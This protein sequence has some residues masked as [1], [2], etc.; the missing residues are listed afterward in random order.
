MKAPPGVDVA[1]LQA[2]LNELGF[3]PVKLR[4]LAESFWSR[5]FAFESDDEPMVARVGRRVDFYNKDRIAA[6]WA[7]AALPVP[8]INAIEPF[9]DAWVAV[10][11]R[12]D[13]EPLESL[14]RGEFD[15]I[16]DQL[17]AAIQAIG[18][19]EPVGKG[20]GEFDLRG[21][22]AYP[23]WRS[24]L[25]S[26]FTDG[27]KGE[28]P[29]RWLDHVSKELGETVAAAESRLAELDLA[30]AARSPVHADLQHGNV[31]VADGRITG[32]FDWGSAAWGDPIYESACFEYWSPWH[33]GI[34]LDRLLGL[35]DAAGRRASL[36]GFADRRAACVIHIGVTH[37]AWSGAN[38][39]NH[40]EA[41]QVADRL[42]ELVNL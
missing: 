13:G 24:Y 12:V 21:V 25:E 26:A 23:S 34:D 8:A 42:V 3:T 27:P 22:G 18:S 15:L 40:H 11:D 2:R 6:E 28:R 33:P 4:P 17:A 37:I 31:H 19:I 29:D 35:L 39:G 5:C 16:V 10:S 32:I 1:D 41:Q 7:N 30:S 20:W 36:P 9:R 14:G 38:L